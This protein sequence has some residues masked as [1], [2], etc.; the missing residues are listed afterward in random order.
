MKKAVFALLALA[1]VVPAAAHA[2]ERSSPVRAEARVLRSQV[3]IGDEVRLVLKVDHP[4]KYT[5]RPPDPRMMLSPFE[6]KSVE[7]VPLRTGQNRVEEMFRMT[8]TVFE[9]G[10]LKVPPIPVH[11]TDEN[12]NPGEA[13][14][15]PVAV[16]VASVGKKITDKDDI[17][18][19]KGPVSVGLLAFWNGLAFLLA[20]VL[21]VLLAV[22]IA[23]RRIRLFKDRESRKPPH[24]R[25]HIEIERLKDK[26]FLEERKYKEF[27][28]G[29]SD[30]LRR[31][32]ERRY[33]V[34]AL[35]RTTSELE[36]ELADL[37]L[38]PAVREEIHEVLTQADLVKFAKFAPPP[39]LAPRLE[40]EIE[41]V[42]ERTKPA[43][44][45][46]KKK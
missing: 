33:G 5:V 10:D 17:R 41:D 1:C 32:L 21:F 3:R 36:A 25:A 22:K 30:V 16:K 19:I 37:S 13:Y 9:T 27:Y 43:P 14:T 46:K 6:I 39:E 4:R 45:E 35:D 15:E 42:A 44:E 20:G 7:A 12:G 38:D 8:L 26:G 31:Y 40:R 11:Y 34:E 29:L 23:L 18:P 28:S 24:V 2:A